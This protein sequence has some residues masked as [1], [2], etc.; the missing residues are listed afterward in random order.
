MD[1]GGAATLAA[2]VCGVVGT[3]LSA[4]LTQRAADRGRRREQEHAE[5]LRSQRNQTLELRACYVA[6]NTAARHYLAALTDE[7]FALGRD[8]ELPLAR[9]RLTDARDHYRQV[10]AEA[11]IWVPDPVLGLVVGLNREL[12]S[13]YGMVRRLDDRAGRPGDSPAAA[14]ADLQWLWTALRGVR[15]EMRRELGVARADSGR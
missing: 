13:I 1:V 8:D 12:G 15:R 9:K 14:E 5:E 11:Q 2:A 3:L 7:L 4:L 10:Y 6:F